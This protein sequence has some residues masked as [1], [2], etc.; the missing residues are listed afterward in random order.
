M[1]EHQ[2]PLKDHKIFCRVCS[3]TRWT[4]GKHLDLQDLI[5]VDEGCTNCG[6]PKKYKCPECG[7]VVR[8][9][10]VRNL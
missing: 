10:R 2:E 4:T 7:H 6:G 3:Y 8:P 1:T 9:K 5:Q